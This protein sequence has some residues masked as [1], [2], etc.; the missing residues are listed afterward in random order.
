MKGL[1]LKD[2]INLKSTFKTYIFIMLVFAFVFIPSGNVTL[3]GV[4]IFMSTLLVITTIAYDDLAKWDTYALTMPI[5]R[6]KMVASKYFVMV[7]LGVFGLMISLVMGLIS[8]QFSNGVYLEEIFLTILIVYLMALIFGSTIIPLIYRFGIE[9]ARLLILLV[10]LIPGIFILIVQNI[11]GLNALE[12]VL[13]DLSDYWFIYML[14]ALLMIAYV[15]GSYL[16]STKI[17]SKKEF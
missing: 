2:F 6:K 8:F 17:Y 9:K 15:F 11:F 16:I 13:M 10:A 4:I 14:V 7:I 1:I 5:T 12:K 3:F